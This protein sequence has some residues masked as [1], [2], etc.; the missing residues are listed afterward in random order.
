MLAVASLSFTACQNSRKD[1]V[2]TFASTE[3]SSNCNNDGFRYFGEAHNAHLDSIFNVLDKQVQETGNKINLNNS[4]FPVYNEGQ[5]CANVYQQANPSRPTFLNPNFPNNL[6]YNQYLDFDSYEKYK[7]KAEQIINNSN[8]FTEQQKP[9]LNQ[10]IVAIDTC[11]T[12]EA[13]KNQIL[14]IENQICNLP[15][16][17]R[18][19]MFRILS[20]AKHSADYWFNDENFNKWKGILD[21]PT[22]SARLPKW[23]KCCIRI[24]GSDCVGAIAGGGLGGA[25]VA[26]GRSVIG[27]I[28][29]EIA[30][31]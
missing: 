14:D 31:L 12:E 9:L 8:R 17:Q 1:E 30:S 4:A 11:T 23:L 21:L 27:L 6:P 25:V 28:F 18:P 16:V 13:F 24:V 3:M 22:T 26:S 15:V 5:R 20:V 2:K 19:E 10:L 29:A 7:Q